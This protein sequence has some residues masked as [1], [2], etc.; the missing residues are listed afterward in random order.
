MEAT[1]REFEEQR[2]QMLQ[3]ETGQR[4]SEGELRECEALAH[5][6][7]LQ[8]SISSYLLLYYSSFV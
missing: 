2:S 8:G 5:Q 3:R 1:K 4:R 7:F 6:S